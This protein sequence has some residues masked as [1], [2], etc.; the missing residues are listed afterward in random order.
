MFSGVSFDSYYGH[1]NSAEIRAFEALTGKVL[2]AEYKKIALEFN[3]AFV[4]NKPAFKFY[5][6]LLGQEV[7]CSPGMFLPFG[8]I[9]GSFETM[10]IKYQYP[11]EDFV[12]DLI[13][14]SVLGNGDALCFDYRKNLLSDSPPVVMWHHEATPGSDLELSD[15]AP[16]FSDF[17]KSLSERPPE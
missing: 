6:R 7:T 2:P 17:L 13:I 9:D 4:V 3:G 5:N 15:V 10:E 12:Q 11:P 1:G 8:K 14:F 16:S